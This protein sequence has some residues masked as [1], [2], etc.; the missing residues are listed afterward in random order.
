MQ[1]CRGNRYQKDRDVLCKARRAAGIGPATILSQ[2]EKMAR[3]R[4]RAKKWADANRP[5]IRARAREKYLLDPE[6]SRMRNVVGYGIR[7]TRKRA[8]PGAVSPDGI[9]QRM[10]VLGNK[11]WY[12]GGPFDH[13]DHLK[14]LARGGYHILANLRPACQP[15]NSTK[16]A[17]DHRIWVEKH[18]NQ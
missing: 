5:R 17:Q 18:L 15:C 1:T 6:Y 8:S 2:E 12:C 11:C 7:K 10:E 13:V 4:E 16:N 14:P 3:R 9:R